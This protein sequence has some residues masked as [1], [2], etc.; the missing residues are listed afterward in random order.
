MEASQPQRFPLPGLSYHVGHHAQLFG[1]SQAEVP[2]G[3][4]LGVGRSG[5]RGVEPAVGSAVDVDEA[6]LV[7][8]RVALLRYPPALP[9]ALSTNE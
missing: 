2:E 3:E 1:C 8:V 4:Q 5:E 6:S 7:D 9:L